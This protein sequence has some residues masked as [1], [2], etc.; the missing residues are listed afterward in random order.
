MKEL[1]ARRIRNDYE[2]PNIHR[3]PQ[4]LAAIVQPIS[5]TKAGFKS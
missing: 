5:L 1:S 2:K 4:L 3:D